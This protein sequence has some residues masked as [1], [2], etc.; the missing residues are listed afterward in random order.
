MG[1]S[2]LF[3]RVVLR[4]LWVRRG[5]WALMAGSLALGVSVA[6]AMTGLTL[7]IEEKMNRELRAYGPNLLVDGSRTTAP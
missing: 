1:Q 7:D 6:V 3:R 4:S 5:K 2:L